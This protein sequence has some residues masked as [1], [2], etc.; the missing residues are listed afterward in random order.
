MKK[1]VTVASVAHLQRATELIR[2]GQSDVAERLLRDFLKKSPTHPDATRLLG[3]VYFSRGA[4]EQALEL[5]QRSLTFRVSVDTL[6]SAAIASELLRDFGS[7]EKYFRSLLQ[8]R[9]RDGDACFRLAVLLIQHTDQ[10]LEGMK[11]LEM[12]IQVGHKVALSYVLLGQVAHWRLADRNL[13]RFSYLKALGLE[14]ENTVAMTHLAILYWWNNHVEEAMKLISRVIE[15]DPENSNAHLLFSASL[16]KLGRHEE[17]MSFFQRAV[18]QAPNDISL[19]GSYLNST[20]FSELMG[21]D[22]WFKVHC[23]FDKLASRNAVRYELHEN[24]PNPER[25]LKVGYVSADLYSHAVSVFFEPL[26]E[27]LD[28]NC[29][30]NYLYYSGRTKDKVTAKLHALA[31]SW[32]DVVGLN[33]ME[34]AELIRRDG[35]DLLID[36]TGHTGD[37]R[38]PVFAWRPAPL[39]FTWL[40]YGPTTGM[41]SI[42]YVFTDRYYT[43]TQEH[44]ALY[45]ERPVYLQ[46]YRVFKPPM[47]VPVNSLPALIKGHVTF[48]S[49]NSFNKVSNKMLQLWADILLRIPEACLVIIV[50]ARESVEHVKKTMAERGIAEDR[51]TVFTKLHYSHF[52]QLHNHVDIA[53]DCYPFTGFTTSFNG[54]WMGVPM[55]TMVGTRMPSRTG[56]G[57]LAPLDLEDFVAYSPDDYV[58]KACYWANNLERLGEIR[59]ALRGRLKQS[60]LMDGAAFARDFESILRGKWREWCSDQAS[61]AEK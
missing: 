53:L 25:K 34:L 51:L 42:D 49:F 3:E 52:L 45:S 6:R 56:L 20:N 28:R 35:I 44:A 19:Y 46:C 9:P 7:A 2:D 12:S 30:E 38:L 32:R 39:Q 29:F 22:E 50:H 48:G 5:F 14:P 16:L 43:P 1:V 4:L 10:Y 54:L 26:L 27:S 59:S 17:C 55:V 60:I 41:S 40:G 61:I 23:F 24:A 58:E 15:I 8:M 13:S 57:L 36:L 18:A 31:D 21:D 47:D 11:L 33:D 37:N